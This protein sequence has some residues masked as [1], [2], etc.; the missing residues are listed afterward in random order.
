MR[1]GIGSDHRGFEIK[2]VLKSILGKNRF[3][4][5]DFGTNSL[6]ACDY[7]DVAFPLANAVAC[8]DIDKGILICSSGN[9]MA[10]AAN[11]VQGI[12]AAIG[13]S[14]ETAKLAKTHN[15]ANILVIPASFLG[16][17]EIK[18]II[19][20]WLYSKFEGGRHRRRINKIKNFEKMWE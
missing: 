4:I 2:K 15:D 7:P 1:I 6:D 16:K 9:G 14:E 5:V 8:G 19:E 20:A 12:R 3:N 17:G 18:K 13:Y 10:I 11:K